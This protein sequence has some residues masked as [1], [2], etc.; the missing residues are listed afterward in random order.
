MP[1]H[2][3][4][5]TSTSFAQQIEQARRVFE[6]R[7]FSRGSLAYLGFED[8]TS[9]IIRALQFIPISA[10]CKTPLDGANSDLMICLYQI[11]Q[12]LTLLTEC[13]PNHPKAVLAVHRKVIN[14]LYNHLY[15][16]HS[17]DWLWIRTKS[18]SRSNVR[19][20][21]S[22]MVS[23]SRCSNSLALALAIHSLLQQPKGQTTT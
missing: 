6:P 11:L 8:S 13:E 2:K 22:T 12:Q 19:N 3:Q 1:N 23:R 15:F 14:T 18:K 21:L 9:K 17:H 10:L 20:H 4:S 5:I 16:L 7:N